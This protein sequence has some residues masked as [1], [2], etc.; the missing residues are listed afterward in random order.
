MLCLLNYHNFKCLESLIKT[1]FQ[2][3]KTKQTNKA[4]MYFGFKK[5]R[6]FITEVTLEQKWVRF[7]T[8]FVSVVIQQKLLAML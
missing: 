2:S 3:I 8:S 6:I 7:H 5:Y 4:L 1:E